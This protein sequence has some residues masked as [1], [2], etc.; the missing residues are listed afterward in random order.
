MSAPP[1]NPN[2]ARLLLAAKKLAPL[3][4]Q[5]AFV[6]GAVTALLLTDPAAAPV[7]PTLDIDAIAAVAS[8]AEFTLLERML[9]G[10]GFRHS[11]QE[12]GPICR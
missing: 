12:G 10:L 2:L 3:M 7:R 6:G 5:I 11:L 1:L 4:D 9:N 8:Y